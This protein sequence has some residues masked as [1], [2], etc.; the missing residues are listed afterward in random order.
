MLQTLLYKARLLFTQKNGQIN[1]AVALRKIKLIFFLKI[2][3]CF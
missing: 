3:T 2:E 1:A